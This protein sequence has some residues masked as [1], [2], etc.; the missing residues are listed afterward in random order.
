MAELTEREKAI[1][2]TM[3][4]MMNPAT[5]KVPIELREN[6]L[7][8][9]LKIRGINFTLAELQDFSHAIEKEQKDAIAESFGFLN[10]HPE[11]LRRIGDF[12][13]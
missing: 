4:F 3:F 12:K 7:L 9:M 13:L 5:I 11:L 8:T 6:T 1:I 2:H 10:K